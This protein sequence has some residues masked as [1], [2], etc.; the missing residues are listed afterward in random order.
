MGP[1]SK[2]NPTAVPETLQPTAPISPW[3][4][5]LTG[6]KVPVSRFLAKLAKELP[7]IPDEVTKTRFAEAVAAKPDR[8]GRMISLLQASSASN[9]TVKRIVLE[10][11]EVVIKRLGG[12]R[13]SELL[14]GEAFRHSI[15]DW[16]DEIHKPPKPS[17]LSVLRLLL[18]FGYQ[19]HWLEEQSVIRLI[20]QAI[21]KPAKPR[22]KLPERKRPIPS[23]LDV[24]LS[25]PPSRTVLFSLLVLS[26]AA[27]AAM[28][29]QF[30]ELKSQAEQIERLSAQSTSDNNTITN[31]RAD[32]ATL[33]QQRESFKIRIADLEREM[34]DLRDGYQHK[35]DELRGR[36][37]ELCRGS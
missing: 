3:E 16:L 23:M 22:S 5:Y 33:T 25:A 7:A 8:I 18:N 31:L 10:L 4:D 27:K 37:R 11:A 34:V 9:D 30:F 19:R 35:L 14:D 20:S 6:K 2:S 21:R 28:E 36:M 24:L 15:S 17:D 12:F 32:I 1:D 26:D 13:F 29:E